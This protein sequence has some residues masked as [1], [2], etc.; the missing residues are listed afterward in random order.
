M[1]RS[2][3]LAA[4]VAAAGSA[5]AQTNNSPQ[6]EIIVEGQRFKGGDRAMD[7]F[8]SGDFETA[9]IEFER[10]FRI[11]K[12]ERTDIDFASDTSYTADIDRIGNQTVIAGNQGTPGVSQDATTTSFGGAPQS[13]RSR[14]SGDDVV[15]SGRDPGFQMYMAGLSELQQGKVLEAEKS[16]KRAITLNRTLYDGRMRYAL[17]RLGQGDRDEAREHLDYLDLQS[18]KCEKRAKGCDRVDELNEARATLRQIM[19]GTG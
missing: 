6:D 14:D 5:H 1:F 12:R 13:L 8:M 19:S 16:F 4:A 3:I 10:N 17:I 9:E 2:I 18:R 15:T 11:L 7:A